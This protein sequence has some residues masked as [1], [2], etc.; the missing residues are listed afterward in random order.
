MISELL[1]VLLCMTVEHNSCHT[2]VKFTFSQ[3]WLD[4][5]IA[6]LMPLPLSCFSEIHTGLPFWY[7]LIRV[8]PDKGPLKM[9][10]RACYVW[11]SFCGTLW[12]ELEDSAESKVLQPTRPWWWQ[13]ADMH[14]EEDARVII[15][16]SHTPSPYRIISNQNQYM[17]HNALRCSQQRNMVGNLINGI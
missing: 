12:E 8:L 13:L 11:I 15:D 14:R 7:H 9:L 5:H 16:I 10:T 3:V 17:Y 6:Q 2:Y 1:H 4:S